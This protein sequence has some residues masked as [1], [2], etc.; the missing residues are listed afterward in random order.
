[1][2][3]VATV[4]FA[5]QSL[6]EQGAV[7]KAALK[8]KKI[9]DTAYINRVHRLC[10]DYVYIY[11]DSV[12][13]VL[14]ETEQ[15]IKSINY[16]AG[17]VEMLSW[18]GEA[19]GTLRSYDSAIYFQD[20]ALELATKIG[21][22]DRES[23]I[24]N[25][26]GAVY[27]NKGDYVVASEKFY[28]SL[29]IA[30]AL[31]NKDRISAVLNNLANIFYFQKKYDE[32]EAYYMKALGIYEELNDTLS[33]AIANNNLGGIFLE[34]KE[35]QK[36]L[37]FLTISVETSKKLN[38]SG[39][40][41]A[42]RV[43]MAQTYAE[44]DSVDKAVPLFDVVI[45]DAAIYNDALYSAYGYLGKAK[46]RYKENRFHEAL[47]LADSAFSYADTIGQ[48]DLVMQA[49]ELLAKIYESLGNDA[50]AL[51]NFKLFKSSSD[52]LN[53]L[54]TERA[55]AM[56]EAEY[57]YSKKELQ[58]QR[59]TLQQRWLIFSAFAALVSLGIILFII[60]KNRSRLNIANRRLQQ[61]N[62]EVEQQKLT[63]EDTLNKLQS[64]QA[65]LIHAE[66]MASLGELTAGIAHEIQNPLNFVNNFSEVSK[67]MIE[68]IEAEMKNGNLEEVTALLA[69][70][71]S[72]LDKIESHGKRADGIVKSMLYHS[73]TSSGKKV[74]TALNELCDEYV[75]LSYHGMRAKDKAFNAKL[76]YSF[77]PAVGEL[78]LMPQEIGRVMLNLLNNAFFAVAKKGETAPAEYVPTVKISTLR[79]G[80]Q[81]QIVVEDNGSGI[82]PEIS[83]KIFQPFFTTKPTGSG[84]GLGLSISYD[85]ITKAH[86]GE[87]TLESVPNEFTRFVIKLPAERAGVNL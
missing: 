1:M 85:I 65:Q 42:V 70:I 56:Q 20:K 73:R 3:F 54:E 2:L 52:S 45:H 10:S 12:L 69:E 77:D 11:P 28:G 33:I 81:V 31:E 35:Y 25:R 32:A 63:L 41:L 18:K 34:K 76:E 59:K 87:L 9:E 51:Y 17:M 38:H 13:A 80:N 55:A 30:E 5:Q 57:N 68:D 50:K 15:L 43:A 79:M 71:K 48:K 82:P 53:N 26:L 37:K 46:L 84:T 14:T 60:N 24:L 64:T 44:L 74:M 29:K 22:K 83:S 78:E 36:A 16:K 86:S 49:H 7:L 6:T 66:K 75:R 62:K 27:T 58:F 61:K 4:S 8:D 47:G 19:F 23:S 40:L 67:E 21:N 39:L 72:N